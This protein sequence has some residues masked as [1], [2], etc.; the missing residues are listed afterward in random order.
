MNDP[1]LVE[2]L[3]QQVGAGLQR[4]YVRQNPDGGWGWWNG[5][6]DSLTSAYVALGLVEAKAAGFSVDKNVLDNGLNYLNLQVSSFIPETGL[7]KAGLDAG[8][9]RQAFL[10][11]VLTRAEKTPVSAAVALYDK[12]EWLSLYSRA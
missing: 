12:R 5:T 9:N 10:V 1:A 7:N 11:Y 3:K 8:R 2:N 4:L 6:S